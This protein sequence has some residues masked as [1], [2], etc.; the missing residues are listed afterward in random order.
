M[1]PRDRVGVDDD[2]AARPRRPRASE[3][4]PE[5]PVGVSEE[6]TRPLLLERHHLLPQ[7]EV[8]HH[9]VGSAPT[10]RAQRASTE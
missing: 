9:E 3:R 10:E 8:F 6:W 5:A 2:Q 4:D 1:P 7:R